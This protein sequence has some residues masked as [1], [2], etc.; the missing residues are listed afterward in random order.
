[1]IQENDRWLDMRIEEVKQER[2]SSYGNE[3]IELESFT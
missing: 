2:E 3:S 1:M